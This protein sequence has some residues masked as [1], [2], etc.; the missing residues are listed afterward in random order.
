MS[1]EPYITNKNVKPIK[2]IIERNGTG[3]VEKYLD[4]RFNLGRPVKPSERSGSPMSQALGIKD[5]LIEVLLRYFKSDAYRDPEIVASMKTVM[6]QLKLSAPEPILNTARDAIKVRKEYHNKQISDYEKRLKD[7][8]SSKKRSIASYQEQEENLKIVWSRLIKSLES[9]ARKDPVI[10]TMATVDQE[11]FHVLQRKS[12]V[13]IDEGVVKYID[14]PALE[15]LNK[16]EIKKLVESMERS[17]ADL[18]PL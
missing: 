9:A 17:I 5:E 14:R 8:E 18:I 13:R 2:H 7:Y 12:L 6:M 10:S 1:R 4:S 11:T 3:D 16:E 15:N